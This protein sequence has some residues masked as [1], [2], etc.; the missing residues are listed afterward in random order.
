MAQRAFKLLKKRKD[1]SLGPLYVNCR[2]RIPIG[3]W[4]PA[5]V[6][7]PKNLA[8]R[9]GWHTLLAPIAPHLS[10]EGRVWCEVEVEDYEEF[11]RPACQ[12]GKWLLSKRMKVIRELPC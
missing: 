6:H 2:Q 3:E 12:G 5:E 10:I 11:T 1:G 8:F 4:L 7:Y 9:P